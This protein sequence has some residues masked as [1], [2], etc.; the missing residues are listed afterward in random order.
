MAHFADNSRWDLCGLHGVYRYLCQLSVLSVSLGIPPNL[1]VSLGIS[2]YP[3]VSLGTP[4]QL[5]P[6]LSVSLGIYRARALARAIE[7]SSERYR[8]SEVGG[9]SER[10]IE[11]ACGRSSERSSERSSDRSN[12]RSSERSSARSSDRAIDRAS[13]RPSERYVSC[14][15]ATCLVI[16]SNV[17]RSQHV[18]YTHTPPSSSTSQ[19]TRGVASLGYEFRRRLF[20]LVTPLARAHA[21]TLASKRACE[22]GS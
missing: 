19:I 15:R 14:D 16:T 22:G 20:Q 8:A 1:L 17:L 21:W 12:D 9:A 18:P 2:W 13:D 4:R 5:P 6:Y 11:R 7:R 10:S 3:S